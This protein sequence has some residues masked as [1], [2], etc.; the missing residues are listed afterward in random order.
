MSLQFAV[1]DSYHSN[2]KNK[3]SF[4]L[5]DS[6]IWV[7]GFRY[8]TIVRSWERNIGTGMEQTV[9]WSGMALGAF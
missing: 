4:L 5:L 6:W 9:N 3:S 8:R 1:Q 2:V 7:F